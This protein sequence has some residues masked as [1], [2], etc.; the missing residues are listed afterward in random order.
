MKRRFLRSLLAVVLGNALYF[1]AFSHFPARAQ[2]QPFHI[3]LGL[4]ID[5]WICLAIY[6]AL[7]WVRWFR[8]PPGQ[9]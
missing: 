2:H 7:A 3:D 5:F 6:G 8:S 9:L 4:A 1:G